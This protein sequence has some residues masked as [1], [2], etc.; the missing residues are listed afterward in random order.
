VF[1]GAP[2]H[3]GVRGTHQ[4]LLGGGK[5]THRSAARR[6]QAEDRSRRADGVREAP[7]QVVSENYILAYWHKIQ[8][9]EVVVSK[10]VRQ[11][12]QK[13]VVELESPRDPW[14]FDL[15]AATAP[16]EFI[17]RFCRHSKGKWIG[18]PVRLEL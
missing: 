6:R 3:E 5:A 2:G 14:V 9:G 1:A 7:E 8:S 12:Y 13:L 15:E 16:I 4:P 11:Q 17:E 10:R 18:Q